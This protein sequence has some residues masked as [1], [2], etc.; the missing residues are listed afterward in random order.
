[1][2]RALLI[3][4]ASAFIFSGSSLMAF[5]LMN[6]ASD[7]SISGQEAADSI[8]VENWGTDGGGGGTQNIVRKAKE[9]LTRYA[10]PHSFPYAPGTQN[11]V[12]GCANVVT[13]CLKEAKEMKDINLGC[14]PTSDILMQ[15][16]WKKFIPP[17]I[18][19]GDVV[20]WQTYQP[21]PSHIGIAVENGG[22]SAKVMNNSSS[23][24]KPV[25]SN[26]NSMKLLY[27]LRK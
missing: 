15:M 17:P 4:L 13:A 26:A 10:R 16:G 2:R 5:H 18:K 11:G 19:A 9:F 24:K 7:A 8:Q 1:M 21:R 23:Q 14:V 22:V 12:L 6:S 20:L 25:L 3:I 27:V